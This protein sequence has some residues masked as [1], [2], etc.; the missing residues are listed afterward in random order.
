[1]QNVVLLSGQ[2][3]QKVPSLIQRTFHIADETNCKDFN[4]I[5]FYNVHS[6]LVTLILLVAGTWKANTV[7]WF[8]LLG[9]K[10]NDTSL[11]GLTTFQCDGSR[12]NRDHRLNHASKQR[13]VGISPILLQSLFQPKDMY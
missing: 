6:P 7:R 3:S 10:I 11:R 4:S 5:W 2:S 8:S 9:A 13:A 1:L 12:S